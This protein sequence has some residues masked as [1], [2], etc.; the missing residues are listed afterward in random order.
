[1]VAAVRSIAGRFGTQRGQTGGVALALG[2]VWV[3]VLAGGLLSAGGAWAQSSSAQLLAPDAAS[4]DFFGTAVAISDSGDTAI[5]GAYRDNA[6]GG[7]DSG[8]ASVYVR[9]GGGNWTFQHKLEAPDAAAGDLFGA[10]VA[11]SAD[12]NLALVGASADDVVD[13]PSVHS[14]AGSAHLFIRSGSSWS[15]LQQL[16]AFDPAPGDAFGGSVALSDTGLTA[17]VGARADDLSVAHTDAGSA[18]VFENAGGGWL[19]QAQLLAPVG[20]AGDGFGG[21]VS[22]SAAGDS[23]LVGA[24][25]DDTTSGTDAG[26]AHVFTRT[27]SSW[28]HQSDLAP[29]AA[30]GDGFGV[31]V[32]LSDTGDTAL[33]GAYQDDTAGGANAGSAQVFTRTGSSWSLAQQLLATDAA[34][35]DQFGAAVALSG[36][37]EAAWVGAYQDDTAAG[38]AAGSAHLFVRLADSSW[39]GAQ[40]LAPDAAAG[41]QFGFSVSLSESGNRAIAGAPFDDTAGGSNA[42]S[43]TVFEFADPDGDGLPDLMDNCPGV[44]NADQLD[45]DGDTQGDACDTDDD[46]DGLT[47]AEE[48]ALGT[49]P[50]LADTDGDGVNDDTD[51]FPLDPSESVDSDGDGVGDNADAFPFDPTETVDTDGDLIGNN[52]DEDDDGDGAP[53]GVEVAVGTD[54]LDPAS[55]PALSGTELLA[56]AGVGAGG[57][58]GMSVALAGSGDTALIGVP[59]VVVSASQEGVFFEYVRDTGTWQED[60]VGTSTD[61]NA[62]YVGIDVAL[63]ATGERGLAGAQTWDGTPGR[64]IF[65]DLTAFPEAGLL[66]PE[67]EVLPDPIQAQPGLGDLFGRRVALSASGDTALIGAPLRDDPTTGET[68]TGAAYVYTRDGSGSWSL[69]HT[70]RLASGQMNDFFG[71]ALALSDAGDVALIGAPWSGPFR[72]AAYLATRDGSGNWSELQELLA[73]AAAAGDVFGVSVALSASGDLA[74]V[75][76][77]QSYPNCL[78][79]SATGSGFAWTFSRNEDGSYSAVQQLLPAAGATGDDFGQSVALSSSGA[80]ALVGA[81]ELGCTDSGGGNPS[82]GPGFAWAF[83]R[84]AAGDFDFAHLLIAPGGATSDAFGFSLALSDSGDTALIGAPLDDTAAGVDAG[85]AHVFEFADADTDGVPDFADNCPST[86]NADQADL[87]ADDLGDVCDDDRDGDGKSNALDAFPDDGAATTDTDGDGQ[88]DDLTGPSTTGLVEDL[89]DDGD[90]LLDTVETNTTVFVDE[91]DTGTDPLLADSDGDGF[92]D[93]FEVSAGSDPTD[94]TSSPAPQVPALGPVGLTAL[95]TLLL[96]CARRGTL[97]RGVPV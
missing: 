14:D 63:S 31:S 43:A 61:P 42:G 48:A 97:S 1:M 81:D 71:G 65:L 84:D 38:S 18:H 59:L 28:T 45:T 34:A 20:A 89:D 22:L 6:G 79:G 53:D 12:G 91:N 49:D 67:D 78:Y 11:L 29:G 47:D 36:S 64:G 35:G 92:G 69:E 13:P 80:V 94:G 50:L 24:P 9:D 66:F 7:T 25:F 2:V 10:S 40:V 19:P 68:L 60:R 74:L 58:L 87:D 8:S 16:V 95:I 39:V 93:G 21:S 57:G 17:L 27:G 30:A 56:P 62:R 55:N 82:T 72:G 70:F 73:P 4:S 85:S 44:A 32:S 83:A 54:P 75:G 77:T 88:P 46:D 51:A 41:D 37:G 23:A 3:L 33:V 5:V 15:H 90:G 52:A 86:P 26:S 76:A 96:A